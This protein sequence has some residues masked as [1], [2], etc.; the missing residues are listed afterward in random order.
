MHLSIHTIH[1]ACYLFKEL[2]IEK[3]YRET[4]LYITVALTVAAKTIEHDSKI[5]FLSD[6]KKMLGSCYTIKKIS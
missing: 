2:F 3:S 4:N 1:L 6:I 5:P